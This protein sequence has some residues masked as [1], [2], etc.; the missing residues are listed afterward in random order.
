ME[1]DAQ[2]LR[3]LRRLLAD[4]GTRRHI[5]AATMTRLQLA[6][7]EATSNAI[8][9][10]Y[11]DQAPATITIVGQH[12]PGGDLVV[13][14]T[15]TGTWRTPSAEPGNRGRGTGI[16]RKV[17]DAFEL[18]TTHAGTTVKLRFSP[19]GTAP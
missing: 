2:Q 5:A 13:T 4:W 3:H 1:P 16:M 19:N 7:S 9:H 11:H 10:A 8:E 14:V 17:S 15:D 12:E 6:V 18:D